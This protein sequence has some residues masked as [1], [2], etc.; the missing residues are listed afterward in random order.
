WKRLQLKSISDARD[1]RARP[2]SAV[3]ATSPPE[4]SA[5]LDE[6]RQRPD[7][8]IGALGSGSDFTPF[9]QHLGIAS[10]NLGFGG[11][12]QGGIYHSIYDDFYWFTHFSDTAFVYGRA[13]A[14]AAGQA[15]MRLADADVLPFA[16]GTLAETAQRYVTELQQLRDRRATE[17]AERAGARPHVARRTA[18]AELVHA[19]ALRAGLLYGLRCEEHAWPS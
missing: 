15:V 14:Q 10:L 17:I 8:R 13:L 12:D 4:A 19:S 3:I 1:A 18:Q 2:E 9:L 5:E 16:F 6:L 7:L 11:E